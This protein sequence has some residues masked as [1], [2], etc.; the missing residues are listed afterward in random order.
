MGY[1]LFLPISSPSWLKSSKALFP[2]FRYL[3]EDPAY[4]HLRV[5]PHHLHPHH[6]PLLFGILN[7]PNDHPGLG[8]LQFDNIPD[9]G[10]SVD[11]Q[12]DGEPRKNRDWSLH[13][14][15]ATDYGADVQVLL[16]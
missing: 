5:Q 1:A 3:F 10:N 4:L 9:K 7:L 13:Y 14:G 12:V 15:S 2:W 6:C 16:F 8:V 11:G